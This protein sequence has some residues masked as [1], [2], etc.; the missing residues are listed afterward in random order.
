MECRVDRAG[1]PNT[2][3]GQSPPSISDVDFHWSFPIVAAIASGDTDEIGACGGFAAVM[4]SKS[5]VQPLFTP[6]R[7]VD[8][9]VAQG[10]VFGPD[11]EAHRSANI[12]CGPFF[13]VDDGDDLVRISPQQ[14][15]TDSRLLIG[16]PAL[17]RYLASEPKLN[18]H[19]AP[20]SLHDGIEDFSG[21]STSTAIITSSQPG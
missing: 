2:N 17:Q 18:W 5:N 10:H 7:L 8:G 4:C 6:A 20:Q 1:R 14:F 12:L 13:G 21:R 9:F 16:G 3:I 15:V 11:V 19:T